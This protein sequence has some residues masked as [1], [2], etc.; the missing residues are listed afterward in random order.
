MSF[1]FIPGCPGSGMTVSQRDNARAGKLF[2]TDPNPEFVGQ[3]APGDVIINLSD[4]CSTTSSP[5]SEA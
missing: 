5:Q 2:I 4:Q 3:H 1:E